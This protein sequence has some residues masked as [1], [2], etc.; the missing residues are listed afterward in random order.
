MLLTSRPAETVQI[1][2]YWILAN[3][4]DLLTG[5]DVFVLQVKGD[6]KPAE[7]IL[8][9]ITACWRKNLCG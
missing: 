1:L 6:S 2:P 9:G 4:G 3:H 7:H 8:E 5:K